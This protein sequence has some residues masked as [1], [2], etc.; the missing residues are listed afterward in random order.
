MVDRYEISDHPL[1]SAITL[2]P[3]QIL[4]F[5]PHHDQE[6]DHAVR[7]D[8]IPQQI[9]TLPSPSIGWS[10]IECHLALGSFLLTSLLIGRGCLLV[11]YRRSA[12]IPYSL[13]LTFPRGVF[14]EYV[15]V[16]KKLTYLIADHAM[17]H[18]ST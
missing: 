15:Y 1:C 8:A 10:I 16:L 7:G 5:S 11:A 18:D 12:P 3:F 17:G 6:D 9:L 2:E 14:S 4:T 13:S